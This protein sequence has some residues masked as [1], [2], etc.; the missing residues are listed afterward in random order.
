MTEK[1]ALTWGLGHHAFCRFGSG[2]ETGQGNLLLL[3][4]LGVSPCSNSAPS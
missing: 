4:A 2:E 3:R 1:Q